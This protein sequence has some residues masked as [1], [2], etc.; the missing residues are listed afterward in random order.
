M[1]ENLANNTPTTQLTEIIPVVFFG[2]LEERK[3]LCT[4][5]EAIKLLDQD[6]QAQIKITFM[7]KVVP[8]YSAEL[9]HLNSFL[10]YPPTDSILPSVLS[11]LVSFLTAP[12]LL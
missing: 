10:N 4:F 1:S 3:G 2:R 7:G 5:V 9:K 11:F 6:L 12:S 8:L